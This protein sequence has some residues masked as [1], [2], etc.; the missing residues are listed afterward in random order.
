[1]RLEFNLENYRWDGRGERIAEWVVAPG[2]PRGHALIL[3]CADWVADHV[4]A[5]YG[6]TCSAV[7]LTEE[8]AKRYTHAFL[9]ENGVPADLDQVLEMLST[10]V[11]IPA[12]DHVD[13]AITLDFYNRPDEEGELQRTNAGY[14]I[15]TTKYAKEPTWGNSRNSRRK[16]IAALVGAI[17]THPILA[18]AS[19]I[20]SAPGHLADGKGFGEVLAREVAGIVG[21]PY[22]ET[23]SP[24]PR[25]QQ[26][27]T[28]Q[29]LTD[30]FTVQSFL[31]GTVIV[32]DD[33]FH[34]GGSA[35]GAAAA[36][37]RAGAERVI[38]LT[39]ARTIRW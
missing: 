15:W 9:F 22:V 4:E 39:V 16:M 14:W 28:P 34:A 31:S 27:E 10:V 17:S 6:S 24:G 30:V 12:P 23:T 33:V 36:A 19:A 18:N 37:R 21:I 2:N 25:P 7:P 26:K 3:K 29:D 13:L 20:I 35:S 11:T 38:S 8:A 32:L 1:M 5:I